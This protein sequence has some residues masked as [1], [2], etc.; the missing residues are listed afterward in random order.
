MKSPFR[1]NEFLP[2]G[3]VLTTILALTTFTN[4]TVA[5]DAAATHGNL[6]STRALT[7]APAVPGTVV[8]GGLARG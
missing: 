3:V 1:W 4:S 5:Q 7:A 6:Q 8:D 2:S